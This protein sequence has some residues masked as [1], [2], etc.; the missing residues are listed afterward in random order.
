MKNVSPTSIIHKNNLPFSVNNYCFTKLIGQVGFSEVFLGT[1]LLCGTEYVAKVMT[2]D[3]TDMPEHWAIFDAEVSALK[4]LDHP[5]IIKLYDHFHQ[6]SQLFMILEYCQ[7]GSL[8]DEVRKEN[9]LSMGRF[10]QVGREIVEALNYCHERGIAHRDI[11]T[12]NILLDSNNHVRLA[13]F[14][15]SLQT[16]EKRLYH[17][18]GG[19]FEYAAPEIFLKRPHDP[20]PGDIWALGVVFSIM[21]SGFSPW[22]CD[23]FGELKALALQAQIKFRKPI[24]DIIYDLIRRMIVVDP[25]SRLTIKEVL[26]HPVFNSA[27][28]VRRG[29]SK[30]LNMKKR[31]IF[32]DSI[33]RVSNADEKNEIES[34]FNSVGTSGNYFEIEN[35]D[36]QAVVTAVHSVSGIFMLKDKRNHVKRRLIKKAPSVFETFIDN[37]VQEIL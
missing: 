13:D 31:K 12:G 11:K 16:I 25:L 30:S 10:Q 28:L 33:K 6:G 37:D 7:G 4:K 9:G 14:G 21:A 24:P 5:R 32:W 29:V 17:S 1:N 20:M 18:L 36:A 19:S 26:A 2:V 27:K 3:S 35:N 23:S 15:L 8:F 34:L 22:A